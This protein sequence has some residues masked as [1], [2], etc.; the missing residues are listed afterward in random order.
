MIVK[1]DVL[2]KSGHPIVEK[3][4]ELTETHI[5]FLQKFLVSN[6][7]VTSSKNS[8]YRKKG[9]PH[10][11]AILKEKN[12]LFLDKFEQVVTD[13]KGLYM[14]WKNNI[15]IE[16]F[17]I[18][19]IFIPFFEEAINEPIHSIISLVPRKSQ[20]SFFYRS[21]AKSLLSIYLAKKLKYEK[22]DWLQIGFAALL[23]DCGKAKLDITDLSEE[24]QQNDDR[25]RVHPIYSYKMVENVTT[26]TQTAKFAILHHHEYLDGSGFPAKLTSDQINMYARIVTVCDLF[27]TVYLNNPKEIITILENKK[28]TKL[29]PVVTTILV[30]EL[31]N[32]CK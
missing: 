9:R 25:W 16:M 31:I 5:E 1:Q 22:K 15:P 13:Y 2:G 19:K 28:Q 3:Q 23:S 10:H 6:I 11:L 26:L 27:Y 4:T 20:D 21:V 32:M 24:K 8:K 12:Q 18:R 30:N 14:T 7:S 17:S 29:D